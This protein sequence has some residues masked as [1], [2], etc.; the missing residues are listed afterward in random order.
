MYSAWKRWIAIRDF[1]KWPIAM[2]AVGG[3]LITATQALGDTYFL[4]NGWRIRPYPGDYAITFTGNLFT[5]GGIDSPFIPATTK[6]NINISQIQS[7][8]VSRQII[9]T[10]TTNTV[11]VEV[12][13]TGVAELVQLAFEEARRARQM[14]TNKAVV[15]TDLQTVTIY[16]DDGTTPL[17]IFSVTAD[18]LIRAPQTEVDPNI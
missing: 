13:Q 14:A 11:V 3:E 9:D 8:V 18:Q 16:A 12:P 5:E 7:A 17:H 4:T 6:S 15:S 10:T 2:S 1:S